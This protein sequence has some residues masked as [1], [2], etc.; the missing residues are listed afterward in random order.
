MNQLAA[1]EALLFV[2]GEQGLSVKELTASLDCKKDQVQ[3]LLE[4]LNQKYLDDSASS[5]EIMYTAGHYKLATKPDFSD[6]IKGLAQL[7]SEKKLTQAALEILAI[8]AY[9]QP[10][11]RAEIEDIRG[12]QS[13]GPLSKLQIHG[14]VEE[15]GRLDLPGR[16]VI[17]G[18]TEEFLDYFG[19]AD[20]EDLPEIERDHSSDQD[21]PLFYSDEIKD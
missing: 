1:L 8:V 20:L 5:L 7:P 21:Q 11:T 4:T 3:Q 19:L 15:K 2:S 12:V 14:L 17:Y 10:V 9:K 18:T 16:P 6:L 13:S